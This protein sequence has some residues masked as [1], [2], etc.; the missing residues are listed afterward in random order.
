MMDKKRKW[1]YCRHLQHTFLPVTNDFYR[2]LNVYNKLLY[3]DAHTVELSLV[4]EKKRCVG[5]YAPQVGTVLY[6]S[7]ILLLYC[8]YIVVP[9][10]IGTKW[11][12][13]FIG[14]SRAQS[15]VR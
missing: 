5:L 1:F 4:K 12:Y 14:T 11:L 15:L 6:C 9:Y 3:Q 2:S 7:I 8:M 13:C 10:C